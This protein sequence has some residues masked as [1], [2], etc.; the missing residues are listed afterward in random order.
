M[1]QADANADHRADL[2]VEAGLRGRRGRSGRRWIERWFAIQHVLDID[3]I[4]L[5]ALG[6]GRLV[7]ELGIQIGPVGDV[8]EVGVDAKRLGA[9]P[10]HVADVTAL[11]N[12]R[13][14]PLCVVQVQIAAPVGLGAGSSVVHRFSDQRRQ[15][16]VL[17]VVA[18][19]QADV[20]NA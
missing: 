2:I 16:D 19:Q 7:A 17:L 10:G 4:L 14:R 3:V 12:R 1:P 20:E 18:G 9:V 5:T 15:D 11:Q 13:P 8:V 6:S